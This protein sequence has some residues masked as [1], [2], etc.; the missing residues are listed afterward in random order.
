[1]QTTHP[2][3]DEWRTW[4][5]AQGLALRTVTERVRLIERFRAGISEDPVTAAHGPIVEWMASDGGSPRP[6]GQSTRA[7]YRSALCAWFDWLV[8]MD[9][10]PDNPMVKVGSVRVPKREARPVADE[11]LPRLLASRM[12]TRTRVMVLLAAYAG[13][14]VH[15]IA[16]VRGEDFDII[17][18]TLTVVGKGGKRA[19]MPLHDR[20]A[21]IAGAMP[22]RGWWFPSRDRTGH[23]QARSVSAMI[24]QVMRRAGVPGTPHSLRHWFATTLVDEDVDI[25][26]VQELLRHASLATTQ[27]YTRVS[28]ERRRAAVDKLDVNRI[29]RSVA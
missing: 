24:S 12:H 19:R 25:R 22:A 4:Q 10:R 27:I 21:E 7:T 29:S 11:H 20:L 17:A 18:R 8:R 14:R 3:I 15:E 26:T 9:Y 6:W 28:D 2:R 1:M 23:V 5:L 13:L 16:K